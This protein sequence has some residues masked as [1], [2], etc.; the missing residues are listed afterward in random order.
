MKRFAL[1]QTVVELILKDYGIILP[2]YAVK[3]CGTVRLYVVQSITH[4][5]VHFV[6]YGRFKKQHQVKQLDAIEETSLSTVSAPS[7]SV[8]HHDDWPQR[9]DLST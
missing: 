3:Y 2:V 4:T 9:I 8:M 5:H 1:L 7:F 6:Q